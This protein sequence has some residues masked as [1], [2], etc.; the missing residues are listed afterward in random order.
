MCTLLVALAASLATVGA[1][2]SQD[3]VI[4]F[5]F[6]NL[7]NALRASNQFVLSSLYAAERAGVDVDKPDEVFAAVRSSRRQHEPAWRAAIAREFSRR[8]SFVHPD[9][10]VQCK[11][12]NET[13]STTFTTAAFAGPSVFLESAMFVDT[14]C[15]GVFTNGTDLTLTQEFGVSIVNQTAFQLLE[16]VQSTFDIRLKRFIT[17]VPTPGVNSSTTNGTNGG[18]NNT[19]N[20]AVATPLFY[21]PG[22][23]AMFLPIMAAFQHIDNGIGAS[24]LAGEALY[25]NAGDVEAPI[26]FIQ[27]FDEHCTSGATAMRFNSAPIDNRYALASN[28]SAFG[29]VLPSNAVFGQCST[30]KI[31]AVMASDRGANL[32]GGVFFL[33]AN[34]D[35]IR[36]PRELTTKLFGVV[37]V[38]LIQNSTATKFELPQDEV[39]R[40]L[41]A[42]QL[43]ASAPGGGTVTTAISGEATAASIAAVLTTNRSG[44]TKLQG[45]FFSEPA[46][47]GSNEPRMAV[48]PRVVDGTQTRT[49][50]A[51]FLNM[52]VIDRSNST[53][54]GQSPDA[55]FRVPNLNIGF[56]CLREFLLQQVE[57]P[58]TFCD[59]AT[60]NASQRTFVDTF[61]V[62]ITGS[63]PEFQTWATAVT[64]RTSALTPISASDQ[65]NVLPHTV[66]TTFARAFNST[67]TVVQHEPTGLLVDLQITGLTARDSVQAPSTFTF[68]ISIV[69]SYARPELNA[70]CSGFPGAEI[71]TELVLTD[72]S[73]QLIGATIGQIAGI[74]RHAQP[75]E[76]IGGGVPNPPENNNGTAT[77]TPLPPGSDGTLP[78]VLIFAGIAIVLIIILVAIA[79]Q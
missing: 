26:S 51:M 6:D 38:A 18:T 25:V 68:N 44:T 17:L 16:V 57:V 4:T 78:F 43:N 50:Q 13:N 77:P 71:V 9:G 35:G 45:G 10:L 63:P 11:Q 32:V 40:Y 47:C 59:S 55:E 66:N 54:V 5:A 41:A 24:F 76:C 49:D 19:D 37:P 12:A 60:L 27:G 22:M 33:D 29:E 1:V 56:T 64:T 48:G 34:A 70:T 7:A 72:Y 2:T 52:A 53:T 31:R 30:D 67:A 79:A 73:G 65:F 15:D 58:Q 74:C 42:L 21:Q 8:A 20:P 28:L 23:S 14:N 3:S 61:T 46:V 75:A 39:G 62:R 69:T 36:Q